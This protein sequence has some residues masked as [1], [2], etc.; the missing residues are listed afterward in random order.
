[1]E[2][3]HHPKSP[4]K[5]DKLNQCI[6]FE[7]KATVGKAAHRG[8]AIHLDIT[9]HLEGKRISTDP[10][11]LRSVDRINR[12]IS[13]F[14]GIEKMMDVL[15]ISFEI[16]TFGTLDAYG[17][18][19]T[20]KLVILDIKTGVQPVS[21]YTHQLS[22][23]ALAAMEETGETECRCVIIPHDDPDN[24][25]WAFDTTLEECKGLIYPLFDRIKK[26]TE[27]PR[28]ND[29]CKWC[30]KMPTCSEW[31]PA[32][33]AALTLVDQLPIKMTPEWILASP[34][35]AGLALTA[36]KSLENIFDN[37]GV[38]DFVKLQ[39]DG[40]NHVPGWK[41]QTRKGSER[42][43]TKAVKARWAQLTDEPIPS[44][45]GESTVSL[46]QAK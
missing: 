6:V 31:V 9:D 18:D 29:Y 44:S 23:Y 7:G 39:L 30:A 35:N 21:S 42:L 33:E 1:M 11:I 36:L 13:K 37:L 12:Q 45:I 2:K 17:W 8:T 28:R 20:G 16:L 19:A 10:D 24:E 3:I 5:T 38:K 22:C 26:G 14:I 43:D 15:G 34:V 40:G 27:A 32:G 4:S 25:A 41:L 46:V